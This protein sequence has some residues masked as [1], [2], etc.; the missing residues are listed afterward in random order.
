MTEKMLATIVIFIGGI[1][2]TLARRYKNE[3]SNAGLGIAGWTIFT[4]FSLWR[5]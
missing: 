5:N 3:N 2:L 4:I 1:L